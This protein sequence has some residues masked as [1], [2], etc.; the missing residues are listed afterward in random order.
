MIIITHSAAGNRAGLSLRGVPW[1]R[2]E[3][4]GRP[5]AQALQSTEDRAGLLLPLHT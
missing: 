4:R 2:E 1:P 5:Q 3:L